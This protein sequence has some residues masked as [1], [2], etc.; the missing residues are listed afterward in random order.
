MVLSTID[1]IAIE[2]DKKRKWRGPRGS[3]HNID[4]I[5]PVDYSDRTTIDIKS[6]SIGYE[7]AASIL[8]WSEAEEKAIRR[9]IDWHT[10][11][12]TTVLYLLCVCASCGEELFSPLSKG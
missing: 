9:K 5:L 4:S 11:P 8:E 7:E 3:N 2:P 1:E 12:L 6:E 10:V